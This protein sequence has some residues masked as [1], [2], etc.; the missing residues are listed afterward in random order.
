MGSSMGGKHMVLQKGVTRST[1]T[2]R[3]GFCA[4]GGETEGF[5]DG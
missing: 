1:A 2:L 5:F 3:A 4:T